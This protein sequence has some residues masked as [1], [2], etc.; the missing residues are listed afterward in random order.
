[1]KVTLHGFSGTKIIF[2]LKNDKINV[3]KLKEMISEKTGCMPFFIICMGRQL[4]DSDEIKNS[5][6]FFTSQKENDSVHFQNYGYPDD[7]QKY[8]RSIIMLPEYR[9]EMIGSSFKYI[10]SKK[11]KQTQIKILR[12][13]CQNI[14]IVKFATRIQVNDGWGPTGPSLYAY[15]ETKK[16][17]VDPIYLDINMEKKILDGKMDIKDM[18]DKRKS[19]YKKCDTINCP[20]CMENSCNIICNNHMVGCLSCSIKLSKCPICYGDKKDFTEIHDI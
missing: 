2:D 10:L 3:K 5:D 15:L 17:L 9:R 6:Y 16:C 11:M 4:D 14:I 20:I 18:G 13:C 19:N 7:L 8:E 1:M 12:K